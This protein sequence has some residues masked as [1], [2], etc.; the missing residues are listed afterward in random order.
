MTRLSKPSDKDKS[1]AT[2]PSVSV[3]VPA[4]DEGDGIRACIESIRSL[5]YP[6]FEIVAVNDRSRDATANVLD[7][8][9]TELN[10]PSLRVHHIR[11]GELPDGWLGK[12]NALRV[13]TRG[14][15]SDWLLFVDSDVLIEDRAALRG[16]ME[17][18]TAR[19]YDAVTILTRLDCRTHLEKMMLPLLAGAWAI[20]FQ[21]SLTNDDNRPNLAFANGQF[22]LVRREAYESVG[23]HEAVRDCIV[24]DVELARLLKQAGFKIRFQLGAHLAGTRMHAT[25]HQMFHGWA[26]I[27]SGTARRNPARLIAAIVWIAISQIAFLIAVVIGIGDVTLH[28]DYRWAAA[29]AGHALLALIV[30]MTIYS[31]SR[32]PKRYA[33][34]APVSFGLLTAILAFAVRTC[35]TGNVIWRGSVAKLAA[36]PK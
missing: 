31:G 28:H 35:R 19:N 2:F 27:F 3:V 23:G 10:E 33:L 7:Q 13:G 4:R 20:I 16:C 36:R 11:E 9:S 14:L 30:L 26:R 5:D 29:A 21:I 24:E 6:N 1:V 25:L 34:L 18:V 22:L 15:T 17:L 12:C 32:N 8:I